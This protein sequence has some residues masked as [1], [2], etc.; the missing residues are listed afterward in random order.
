MSILVV[1]LAGGSLALYMAMALHPTIIEEDDP[2]WQVEPEF[3]E[4]P[5][6][7]ERMVQLHL[8]TAPESTDRD[9]SN[10]A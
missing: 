3:Q 8:I 4:R 1:L 2:M 10:A 5:H 9:D 7:A 6:S